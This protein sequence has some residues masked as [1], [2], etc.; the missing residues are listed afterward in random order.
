MFIK[1][2]NFVV[3]IFVLCQVT[4]CAT[5]AAVKP[6]TYTAKVSSNPKMVALINNIDVISVT[7]GQET[8]P[9][10][11]SK[12]NNENFKQALEESLKQANLY[13][14]FN[15]GK[16]QLTAHLVDLKQPLAGLDV[17]VFYRTHYSL[18]N[19]KLNKVIYD[20]EIGTSYTAT[21]K[22]SP[23]GFIRLKMANE[24]AAKANIQQLINELYRL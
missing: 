9:L 8:N 2:V 12:I 15:N 19:I 23:M 18:K 14:K 16:Y 3:L 10:L 5:N 6:M 4:G 7:G 21:F 13:R 20:K 17:T 11:L 24:G 22:D 1:Y